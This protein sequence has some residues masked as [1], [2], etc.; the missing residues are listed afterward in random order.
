MIRIRLLTAAVAL[1]AVAS[2][3]ATGTATAQSSDRIDLVSQ[4]TFVTDDPVEFTLR[5]PDLG[6]DR[7]LR[8]QVAPP[9]EDPIEIAEMLREPLPELDYTVADFRVENLAELVVGTTNLVSVVLP[10]EEIGL[11]LR[12]EPGALPVRLDLLDPNGVVIDTLLTALILEDTT[13]SARIDLGFVADGRTPL[14]HTTDGISIDPDAAV[15]RVAAAIED[16]PGPVLVSFTPETLTALA[17]PGTTGGLSAIDDLRRLLDPHLISLMPWVSVD[18]EAWRLAGET[19]RVIALYA[20]GQATTEQFLGRTPTPI[21]WMDADTTPDA[22]SFLRSVGVSG[23]IVQ[24]EQI[25]ALTIQRAG[26]RPIEV[27]DANAFPMPVLVVDRA[28]EEALVGDDPE[29]VAQHRFTELLFQAKTVGTDRAILLDLDSVDRIPL[30][31]LLELIDTTDR[32]G[33]TSVDELITR[34]PARDAA[35]AV[36][37]IELAATEPPDVSGAASDL[38]L[39]E[40]VLDS[41]IGMVSPEAAPVAPLRTGLTVAMSDELDAEQRLAFT[42]AVFDVVIE[43]TTDFE[44]VESSRVTLATR[45]ATLPVTI[46]N[47]QD[48]PINV[49]VRISSEKLRFPGGDQLDLTLDPGLNELAIPVETVASGDSR[50]LISLTSPD[51]RLDLA[52][53]SVNIRSTAISGLGLVVSLISLAILLT[54]WART[55]VRVRRTRRTA[56][57]PDDPSA[58]AAADEPGADDAASPRDKDPA[59]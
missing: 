33:V 14:S 41:Y 37:R 22:V 53:G 1:A 51:G 58:A 27:L 52:S 57:V 39:T 9:R 24:P 32:L 55:I 43:G 42:D 36:L 56:T 54:W 47:D 38:R 49:I 46:R 13:L 15:E 48:L 40:S 7:T 12:R 20:R 23:G 30:L 59:P 5:I 8:V 11:F 6:P 18:E 34:P 3:H 10:D 44:V 26:D 4:T 19:D 45:T 2:M 17:D 28:F 31:L 29:L 25:D 21:V 16:A 50:I 35:G